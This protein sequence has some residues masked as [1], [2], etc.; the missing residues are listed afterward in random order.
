VKDV[1]EL[2]SFTVLGL[3]ITRGGQTYSFAKERPAAE[4]QSTAVEVWKQTKP[5]AKDVDQTKFTDFLTTLTNLRAE[6]FADKPLSG[7]DELVVVGRSGD[8]A[9]PK[10]E[11]VT[12]RRSG[13]TVQ[14]IRPGDPGAAVVV[15]ADFDKAL[16]LFKE[17]AGIK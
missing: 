2:R 12:F 16:N 1:F 9:S 5:A 4:N 17:L 8:A 3:D 13:A 7:A 15:T 11:R 10:E 14:A 6:K